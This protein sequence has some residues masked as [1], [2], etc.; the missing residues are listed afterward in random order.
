MGKYFVHY[1]PADA[2]EDI[3]A[4]IEA[5]S[6]RAVLTELRHAHRGVTVYSIKPTTAA[7]V[8]AAIGETKNK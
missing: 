5:P 2:D 6:Y 3:R 1:R 4:V 7:D 8:A